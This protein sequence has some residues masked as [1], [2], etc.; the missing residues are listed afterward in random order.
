MSL[1]RN[2]SLPDVKPIFTCSH[3]SMLRLAEVK[4]Y[5]CQQ[6]TNFAGV[7][8]TTR[9]YDHMIINFLGDMKYPDLAAE[10]ADFLL[11]Y[12]H[13]TCVLCAMLR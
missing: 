6:V 2:A 4:M 8:E 7:L 13:A 9:I 11:R 5:S 10:M 3:V 12:E 1:G